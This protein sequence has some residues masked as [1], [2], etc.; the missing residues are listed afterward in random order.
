M[1]SNGRGGNRY[2]TYSWKFSNIN[3]LIQV[4]HS[5]TSTTSFCNIKYFI[6]PTQSNLLPNAT[7]SF[8]YF[9][10][11]ILLLQVLHSATSSASFSQRNCLFHLTKSN[12]SPSEVE[13]STQRSR[14][15]RLNKTYELVL[16]RT[17]FHLLTPKAEF[18]KRKIIF[19]QFNTTFTT[20]ALNSLIIN[21]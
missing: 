15:Y 13:S 9:R 16:W 4:L 14:I 3:R 19:L 20:L 18:I 21:E 7:I 5:T 12:P 11:F 1:T 8:C 10:Y 2:S 17:W 6:Q